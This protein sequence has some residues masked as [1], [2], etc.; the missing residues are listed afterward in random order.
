MNSA[1]EPPVELP[2][3]LLPVP[4]AAPEAD[5]LMGGRRR[6]EPVPPPVVPSRP[7]ERN[8]A[9]GPLW[10]SSCRCPQCGEVFAHPRFLDPAE[11]EPPCPRCIYTTAWPTAPPDILESMSVMHQRMMDLRRARS[12]GEGSTAEEHR[13]VV[14]A[15]DGFWYYGPRLLGELERI[16]GVQ[17][18]GPG[19]MVTDNDAPGSGVVQGP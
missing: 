2:A 13:T 14:L 8:V 12:L 7:L 18:Q 16:Y 1:S 11:A 6:D 9:V 19:V 17:Q 4:I 10:V 15:S 3:T 5:G